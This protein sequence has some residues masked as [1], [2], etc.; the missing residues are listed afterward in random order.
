MIEKIWTRHLGLATIFFGGLGALIYG[1]MITVTLAHI[2]AISGQV[3]FDMRPMGYSPQDAV[4]LLEGLGA[5]GRRYYLSYQIPLDTVYPALL[6]LTLVSLMRKFGQDMPTH[7]LVRLGI[8]LSIGAALCDYAENLGITAMILSWPDHSAPLVYAS[9][10]A[11]LAKSVLTT[12]AVLVAI[13]IGGLATAKWARRDI[14]TARRT[15]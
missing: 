10:I 12:A 2:K 15:L 8:I 4:A 3:P 13:L 9:S 1:L 6:A 7:R 5:E 14:E 11:T